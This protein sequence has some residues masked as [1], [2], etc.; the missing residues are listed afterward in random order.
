MTSLQINVMLLYS[1]YY[2]NFVNKA[3][4]LF[5]GMI[6]TSHIHFIPNIFI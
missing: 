2:H 1:V 3:N 4:V 6:I 5:Y